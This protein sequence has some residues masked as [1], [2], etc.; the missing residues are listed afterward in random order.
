MTAVGSCARRE[1]AGWQ[2]GLSLGEG[3]FALVAAL[4]ACLIL[5]GLAILVISLSTQDLRVS[6]KLVG[7]KK[8]MAAAEAGIHMI[9]QKFE[10][11][12][13]AAVQT[14]EGYVLD[15]HAIYSISAA[16]RPTA[17]PASIPLAGFS[18]G[19]GQQWGQS[20]YVVDVTGRD[21]EYDT[22]VQIG[23]GIGYGP[24]EIST[25]SR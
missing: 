25:M 3:G 24:I 11:T 20:R 19:G 6:A 4:L 17:G 15:P 8:A 23:V 7:D 16:R 2:A 5:M 18:I 13:L 9:T 14:N 12:N 1:A 21:T 22:T 10:P